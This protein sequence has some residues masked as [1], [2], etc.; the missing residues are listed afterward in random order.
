[1]DED[2][3]EKSAFCIH[4]VLFQRAGYEFWFDKCAGNFRANDG[5]YFPFYA[6]G[7]STRVLT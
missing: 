5:S 6:L 4:V 7:S 1:M 3:K 2:A